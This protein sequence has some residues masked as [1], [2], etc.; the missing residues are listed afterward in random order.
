[1]TGFEVEQLRAG[2]SIIGL[3][4]DWTDEFPVVEVGP[5]LRVRGHPI[6]REVHVQVGRRTKG[7]IVVAGRDEVRSTA[8]DWHVRDAVT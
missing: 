2:D 6:A 1:M 4:G 8:R 3:G 7:A 5:V